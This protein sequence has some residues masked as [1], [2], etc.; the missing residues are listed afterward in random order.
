MGQPRVL[1]LGHTFIRRLRDFIVKNVS[2]YH[3]NLNLTG[4]V[5]VQWH[6]VGGRTIAK[7]R[8]F[9]LGEVL[10]FRPDIL[11]LQIGTN[12]LAQRGMSPLTV[13]SAVEDFVRLLHDEY[14][15]CLI[16]V[17]QTI[18]RHLVGNFNNNVQLLVQ[19]LKTVLEPLPFAIYWTHR[20]FWRASSS[21][22]SYD[23][24]HL[25]REGQHNFFKSIKGAV[26]Q[27]LNRLMT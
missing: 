24:V 9:D 5:A 7:F 11:F 26:M 12:D 2:D 18:R 3:L 16:C 22:L 21:Y 14:G 10:R 13:G 15:V 1:I 4:S 25:N 6:G 23:G 20:G 19:Y 17:G 8:Q 27:C